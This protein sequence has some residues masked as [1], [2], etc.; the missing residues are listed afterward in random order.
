MDGSLV[1]LS[2]REARGPTSGTTERVG[3]TL[4]LGQLEQKRGD[5]ETSETQHA[6]TGSVQGN[7]SKPMMI[8][9]YQTSLSP[10]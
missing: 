4:G 10:L 5:I 3:E 8:L 1:F 9:S 2:W 7:A 6:D